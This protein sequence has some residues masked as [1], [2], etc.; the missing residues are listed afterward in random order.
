[1]NRKQILDEASRIVCGGRE[2]GTPEDNFSE[3]A[4]LWSV[5][6]RTKLKPKDV[7]VM[8]MLMKIARIKTGNAKSDNWIDIA[9]YAA[10][11]GEIEGA[12]QCER[13]EKGFGSSGR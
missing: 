13:G 11:G 2:Y 6:L 1:M 4:A 9:G 7:A 5:Y 10:C 8:M 3:I 12:E